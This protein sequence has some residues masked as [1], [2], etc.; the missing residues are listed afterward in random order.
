MRKLIASAAIAMAALTGLP[1]VAADIPEYP[2]YPEV[3]YPDYYDI[4]ELPEADY[5]LAGSFY[6]RGSAGG[7]L[8]TATGA[9]H[10]TCLITINGHGFG[11]SVGAGIGYE[12]GHGP[13]V[14]LTADYLSNDGLSAT[15]GETASL[16]SGIV[17]ANL[18]YDFNFGGLAGSAAGGFGAYVGAGIGASYNYSEVR[19]GSGTVVNS[20]SSID[21]AVAGMAG[22]TYDMGS[23]V[24]DVGY[25][26]IYMPKVMNQPA[27]TANAYII[28]NN[29]FHEIRGTLRYRLQ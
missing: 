9:Q 28:N 20:G 22:I 21:A 27:A 3:E 12:S 24:A 17:L 14:D 10:C 13:R 23:I 26:G 1:A 25:R 2:E 8:W 18:Y 11:Y 7:N 5:G 16:R 6:L 19:D 4:T 15:N 29:L